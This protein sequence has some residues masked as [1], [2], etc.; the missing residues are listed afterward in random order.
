[1]RFFHC[2]AAFCGDRR[3]ASVM[4]AGRAQVSGKAMLIRDGSSSSAPKAL[5]Q[6]NIIRVQFVVVIMFQWRS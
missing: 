4:F 5:E 6:K 3:R 1:M 2:K